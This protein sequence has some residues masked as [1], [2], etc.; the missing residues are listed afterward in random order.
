MRLPRPKIIC[1][2][3]DNN[4]SA[5]LVGGVR[6]NGTL[7]GTTKSRSGGVAGHQAGVMLGVQRRVEGVGHSGPGVV[8]VE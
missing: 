1:S 2:D 5:Y 7:P 3:T 8:M 6:R 4:L